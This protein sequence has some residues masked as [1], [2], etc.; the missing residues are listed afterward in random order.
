MHTLCTAAHMI[1]MLI[2]EPVSTRATRT[3]AKT[4]VRCAKRAKAVKEIF[5]D[6]QGAFKSK[7]KVMSKFLCPVKDCSANHTVRA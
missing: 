3:K 6:S 7:R 4:P 5:A 1:A 2:N